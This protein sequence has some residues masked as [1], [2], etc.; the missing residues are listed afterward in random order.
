MTGIFEVITT[1]QA[2][3]RGQAPIEST[4]RVLATDAENAIFKARKHDKFAD[5]ERVIS[6]NLLARTGVEIR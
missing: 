4:Y 1:C 5:D 2:E 6:V 3:Q